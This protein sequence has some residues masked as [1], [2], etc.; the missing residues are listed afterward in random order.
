M[1]TISSLVVAVNLAAGIAHAQTFKDLQVQL[2]A[3]TVANDGGEKPLG[4]WFSTGPVV[5]GA[6]ATATFS[7]GNSC[8][9]FAVSSDGSLRDDATVAWKIELTP[10]RV[11]ADAVTFRL[12]W[13]RR[14]APRQ[15]L[16]RLSFDDGKTAG[17]TGDEIELTLR[18]GESWPVDTVQVPSGAK[19]V[20]GRPCG[21]ASSIRASVDAY[22]WIEDE[23]R[24]VAADLWLL[25]RLS[26]GSEAQRGQPLSV[27]GLPNH[28]FRFYFDSIV[29]GDM[30]L[31]V[32]GTLVARLASGAMQI[33]VET[34]CR[35]VGGSSDRRHIGPQ[36][37]VKSDIQVKPSETVEIRLPMLGDR[38]GPFAKRAL[39]IRVRARQLR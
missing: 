24:L 14:A 1:R 34:R 25:E 11:M 30:S 37:S 23:R 29:D 39:S 8:E 19:T 7:F 16:E 9:A 35:W 36:R 2:G 5:I 22:P 15:Q 31:D 10:V 28:P 33:S 4:M 26:D 6:P 17:A 13:V 21:G 20:H 18:P 12:R 38:A 27:R 3:Y 32:Y